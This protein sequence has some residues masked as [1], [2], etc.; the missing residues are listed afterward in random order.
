MAGAF[1]SQDLGV[2]MEMEISARV[3]IVARSYTL[4]LEMDICSC[5]TDA[6]EVNLCRDLRTRAS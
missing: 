1:V 3:V 2:A 6:L 5:S 4:R